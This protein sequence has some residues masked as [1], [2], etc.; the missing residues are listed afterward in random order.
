MSDIHEGMRRQCALDVFIDTKYFDYYYD[1]HYSM[2]K[3]VEEGGGVYKGEYRQDNWERI[4]LAEVKL[5]QLL[6]TSLV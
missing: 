6:I 2:D 5:K 4:D 1:S 3:R